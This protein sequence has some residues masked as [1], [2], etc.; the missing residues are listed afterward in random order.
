MILFKENVGVCSLMKEITSAD[1]LTLK[2]IKALLTAKGRREQGL[3]LAEGPHLV[4]EALRSGAALN[5]VAV[6]KS[7]WE[8]YEA[9][10]AQ[11]EDHGA[12]V[13]LVSD[14]LLETLSDARTPQGIAAVVRIPAR[15]AEDPAL[16][17]D[18]VA[19]VLENLQD[20]GNMGT[21]LR[22]ALAVDAAFALLCGGADPWSPKVVRASQGAVFHLPIVEAAALSADA[23][24]QAIQQLKTMGWHSACGHLAG[25]DFFARPNF[26]RVVLVIG[27]EGAGVSP[28]AAA[29][30]DGLYRLP[31]SDKAESL[32]AAVAAGVMLYDLW[33]KG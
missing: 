1:N 12:Q 24:A 21:I 26:R 2:S 13:L 8:R 18:G 30:C 23:A 17:R 29:A 10:A 32:N 33:R 7:A 15:T 19:V 28:A 31:M 4:Q 3:F 27:N 16:H 5:A 25:Q 20:P 11:C 6:A 9:L 14:R 22:T